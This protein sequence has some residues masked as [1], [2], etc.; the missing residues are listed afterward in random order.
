MKKLIFIEYD[1]Q[2][3][4]ILSHLNNSSVVVPLSFSARSELHKRNIE[5]LSSDLFF[6]NGH[7]SRV[8]KKSDEIIKLIKQNFFLKDSM[9]VTHAYERLF[10]YYFRNHYLHYWLSH[11]QIIDEAV[12][13]IKPEQI[14]FPKGICPSKANSVISYPVSLI[15][16][17]GQAYCRE[18]DYAYLTL[19]EYPRVPR[20][21]IVEPILKS[22][23]G[24]LFKLQLFI[25]GLLC[26]NRKVILSLSGTYNLNRVLKHICENLENTLMVGE[27]NQSFREN[28]LAFFNFSYWRFIKFPPTFSNK[29]TSLFIKNYNKIIS[30]FEKQIIANP[31]TF[32]FTGVNLHKPIMDYFGNG[33]LS[34]LSNLLNCSIGYAKILKIKKPTFAISNHALG[35][36]YAFGELCRHQNIN[37][38]LISHGTHTPQENKWAKLEWDFDSKSMINSHYPLVSIQTPW[39][40]KFLDSK[41][42]LISKKVITGPLLYAQNLRT[43]SENKLLR[44]N[45]YSDN[46]K[47]IILIHAATPF[48]WNYFRPWVNLTQDE[49]IMHINDLIKAVDMINGFFLVVKIRSKSFGGMSSSAIRRLFKNSSNYELFID[50]S[51]E[52]YLIT[53]DCLVSFSSTTIEEALQNKIPVLQYD[54]YNRYCHIPAMELYEEASPT[55]SPIYY[56]ATFTNL[57]FSLKWLRDKHLVKQKSNKLDWSDHILEPPS[58]W[59]QSIVK[60]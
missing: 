42:N 31:E 49:Y 7:H 19:G 53:S 59:L 5:Y 46:H 54:P 26:K 20:K 34:E 39:S 48:G 16:F 50:G 29:E 15:G 4:N 52:E 30:N 2:I 6:G 36:N 1:F 8:L 33:L 45:L 35:Q 37:A 10:F 17:I 51:F 55:I 28:F 21:R 32:S 47:K 13:K 27:N 22:I 14:L 57:L 58:D 12:K 18:N 9:G 38:M 40:E 3:N 56:T 44:K 43:D 25:Y 60:S 23:N 24:V 11:L 41:E